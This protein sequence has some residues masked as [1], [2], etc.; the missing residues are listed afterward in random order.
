MAQNQ[1]I[2]E[3]C[4]FGKGYLRIFFPEKKNT[5]SKEI[6]I[7]LE[8]YSMVN[9][10]I[11]SIDP[12]VDRIKFELQ[13]LD[14]VF[15]PTILLLLRCEETY[16]T[17][18]FIP[19]KSSWQA[20]M[21][22]NKEMKSRPNKDDYYTVN[23]SYR[24]D[25]GYTFNTFFMEKDIV[26]SFLKIAKQL[27][28]EVGEVMPYGMY[29]CD[30]LDY[31]TNFVFFHIRRKVCTMILV[32]DHDLITSYDFAF[33]ETEEVLVNFLL[34][35]SKHEFEL[36][37]R[38]ITHYGISADDPI[39]LR[40]GLPKLGEAVA[41][42]T[43]KKTDLEQSMAQSIQQVT[44]ELEVDWENYE[45]DTTLFSKRYA[46]ANKILRSRYDAIA[47]TL[48]NYTGM[49]SRVTEQA[50]IFH[51][52]ST[53][54]A[55]MDIRNN[56]VMLYLALDPEKYIKSRYTCAL[57]KRKGFEDTACLYK[58]ATAFRYEGA[59]TLIEDLATEK[60]LVPKPQE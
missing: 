12:L 49:K 59:F 48:L 60:G 50:A 15:M 51:I 55:K 20:K 4:N 16:R 17:S 14:L 3:Y 33:D 34:V 21:L 47:K 27:G 43:V 10:V 1:C 37:K 5:T 19:M 2:F 44:D 46:D 56:R 31:N 11:T 42:E 9:G 54:Y 39:D 29:L 22:Y 30:S 26:E 23:N 7:D 45:N 18:M 40:L 38:K 25:I 52:N 53:V 36:S 41:V 35:A 58:I 6:M 32:S 13:K 8:D 24:R 57:S 28:T